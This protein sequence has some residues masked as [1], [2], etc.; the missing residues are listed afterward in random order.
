M[1][2][3]T[4]DNDLHRGVIDQSLLAEHGDMRG[5]QQ[6]K[7]IGSVSRIVVMLPLSLLAIRYPTTR[8][9]CQIVRRPTNITT[10]IKI[11]AQLSQ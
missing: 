10:P 4:P 1:R 7:R 5:H 3:T 9:P 6:H 11:N 8:V 2:S